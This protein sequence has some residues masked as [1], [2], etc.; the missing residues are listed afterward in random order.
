[1]GQP[2]AAP[3]PGERAE[4]TPPGAGR[5][6]L[7]GAG[8]RPGPAAA[9]GAARAGPC[10]RGRQRSEESRRP[11]SAPGSATHC[12]R[13]C[14]AA[15]ASSRWGRTRASPGTFGSFPAAPPGTVRPW[16]RA[17]RAPR[18]PLGPAWGGMDLGTEG[19]PA[20][21]GAAVPVWGAGLGRVHL[22][23]RGTRGLGPRGRE[24]RAGVEKPS[25]LPRLGRS[26]EQADT[27]PGQGM[28]GERTL[29][30]GGLGGAWKWV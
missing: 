18:T 16:S 19:L 28:W 14:G 7:R 4:G 25:F 24:L 5:G 8:A 27:E 11:R 12:V 1:M 2:P 21:V 20:L 13:S 6:Y 10:A 15:I 22:D 9:G 26:R 3:D 29:G 23:P 17:P 30:A